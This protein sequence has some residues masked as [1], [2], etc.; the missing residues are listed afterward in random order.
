MT[1]SDD[2]ALQ[3]QLHLW[4]L[5]F[6]STCCIHLRPRYRRLTRYYQIIYIKVS[7]VWPTTPSQS[8]IFISARL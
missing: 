5:A 1:E 4:N 8:I 2:R 6:D 3:L 7:S